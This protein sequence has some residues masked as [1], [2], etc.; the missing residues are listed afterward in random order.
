[1]QRKCPRGLEALKGVASTPTG[2]ERRKAVERAGS[3][4]GWA[5][6]R[7]A[8]VSGVVARH[9]AHFI[10]TKPT[11]IPIAKLMLVTLNR[12]PGPERICIWGLPI[13][14][15]TTTTDTLHDPTLPTR[16][17]RSAGFTKKTGTP[18]HMSR[19]GR[20]STSVPCRPT[21]SC[22]SQSRSPQ[23][24]YRRVANSAAVRIRCCEREETEQVHCGASAALRLVLITRPMSRACS[25][26]SAGSCPSMPAPSAPW[27]SHPGTAH[28]SCPARQA[29]PS[30]VELDQA[31][32]QAAVPEPLPHRRARRRP[33][34]HLG[35]TT[36]SKHSS[37]LT[38]HQKRLPTL[39]FARTSK[40]HQR[41]CLGRRHDTFTAPL[42][43]PAACARG[44]GASAAAAAAAEELDPP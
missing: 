40:R 29:G 16:G 41:L 14:T 21:C 2:A 5:G 35:A 13:D 10:S 3:R 30:P 33:L 31:I 7:A 34:Q 6:V 44:R 24:A 37:W 20:S 22:G 18:V 43:G 15:A 19:V 28:R 11:K 1:M 38:V 9:S 4:L 25:G 42:S 12:R 36:N 39:T 32:L 17:R 27:C 23:P 26:K 8:D